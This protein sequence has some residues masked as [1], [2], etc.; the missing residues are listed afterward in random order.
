MRHIG[1]ASREED[2]WMISQIMSETRPSSRSFPCLVSE[3]ACLS[4]TIEKECSQAQAFICTIRSLVERCR[5][6]DCEE[7]G[8]L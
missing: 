7:F 4:M 3:S 6:I 5:M 1:H 8:D 2:Q